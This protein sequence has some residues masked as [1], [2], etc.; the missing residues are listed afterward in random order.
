[1]H[2]LQA[3]FEARTSPSLLRGTWDD[4][5]RK[6]Y[7]LRM[8]VAVPLS[9]DPLVWPR[10]VP[11]VGV[12]ATPRLPWIELDQV[13]KA[14]ASWP[15][16]ER[17]TWVIVA[18]GGLAEDDAESN[19]L[20]STIGMEH[21]LHVEASW[22]FIGYDVAD[23]SGIS[24]LC[25]CGYGPESASLRPILARRLNENGLVDAP[26]H[27]FDFRALTDQRVP[28]HAPFFVYGLWV[29]DSELDP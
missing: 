6:Q 7:L 10:H 28:E 3:G 2:L 29:L 8:D 11:G 20:A 5:R 14:T 15:G 19:L 26:E 25:N 4:S 18:V 16:S 24:G 23:G 1:M 27:A 17:G 22:R 12:P 13:L 9:I 21:E